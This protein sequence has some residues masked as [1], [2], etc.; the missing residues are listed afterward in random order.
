L[1]G[2]AVQRDRCGRFVCVDDIE[3]AFPELSIKQVMS[4]VVCLPRIRIMEKVVVVV[5]VYIAFFRV[6]HTVMR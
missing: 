1:Q 5:V 4:V 3:T 6:T 2:F